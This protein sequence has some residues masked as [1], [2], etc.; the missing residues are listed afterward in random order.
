MLADHTIQAIEICYLAPDADT[1]IRQTRLVKDL[2]PTHG[3]VSVDDPTVLASPTA[4]CY[5]SP[6]R[7]T[8]PAEAM[9]LWVR[10][11]F[12]KVADIVFIDRIRVQL[13]E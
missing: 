10:L 11:E 9:T 12:A 6:V 7:G 3:L 4:T 2:D 5:R 8:I 1:F 13:D